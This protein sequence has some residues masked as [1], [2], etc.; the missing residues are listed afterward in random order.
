MLGVIAGIVRRLAGMRKGISN[1]AEGKG[2][3]EL[4]GKEEQ[5]R[6]RA[7]AAG[8]DAMTERGSLGSRA[9][10]VL[11]EALVR[12]DEELMDSNGA[13]LHGDSPEVPMDQEG[14]VSSKGDIISSLDLRFFLPQITRVLNAA[15]LP[16]LSLVQLLAVLQ[17]LATH[18]NAIADEISATLSLV[19]N[20]L[21]VFILTPIPP[22][23]NSPLPV[24]AAIHLLTTL[25]SASRVSASRLLNPVDALL[26]FLTSTPASSPYP[27]S[28]AT[29]LL[30]Q[31]LHLYTTLARYGLYAHITTTAAE[32][33]ARLSSY[34]LAPE[35]D[36]RPLL[37]SYV[38]LLAAW[39]TCASDPH[40]TTPPHDILWSQVSGWG[41]ISVLETVTHKLT[42]ETPDW[43]TWT[44]LWNM[45]A[46]W[47]EGARHNG[48]R[49]GAGERETSIARLRPAFEGKA[50][51]EVVL[52]AVSSLKRLLS[53]TPSGYDASRGLA[54]Y[55]EVAESALVLSAAIRLWLSCL[56][57]DY[58]P[59]P[60]PPFQLPFSLL[61]M[62]AIHVATHPL[63][64]ELHNIPSHFRPFLRPLVSFITNYVWLSR[65]LPGTTPGLWLAQLGT[66]IMRCLPGDEDAARGMLDAVVNLVDEQCL[67][68][69]GWSVP[70]DVWSRG[71]L[72]IL[73]PFLVYG[74]VPRSGDDKQDE[75]TPRVRVAP[76]FP[77]PH[78]LKLATTQCLPST[79][80]FT[81][82]FTR[83][84]PLLPL[85]YLL[86]SGTSPV[87]RHL[88][89]DWDS[90]ETDLVRATLI[91][92]RVVRE[93]MLANGTPTFAMNRTEV[94]FSC[95][96][97]FM[98]EHEQAQG[99]P[100]AS[101]EGREEVFRDDVVGELMEAL[102]LPLILSASPNGLSALSH[103]EEQDNLELAA[104][105]FLG[106]G[107][108]FFQFYTDFVT[109]YDATS[110]GHPLFAAL[111]LP[112]LE[113][114]YAPDY[115]KLLYDDTAHIL[116]TVRTPP[117]RVIGE[118]AGAFLWPAEQTPQIVG[119][120]LGLLIGRRAR[121]PIEGFVRWM[122]V[123]HVA[124]NIWPD[125]R[126]GPSSDAADERGRKL[127][128]TLVTQ[129]EHGVVRDV[130]LYWQRRTGQVVLPPGC[131]DLEPERRRSRHA[132]VKSWAKGDLLERVE[133]LFEVN[134][135][136]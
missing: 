136:Q 47:L 85:D 109:L 54:F 110:F 68:E 119:A 58:E 96:K 121:V 133:G 74:L 55:R 82:L 23:D 107:T 36:S 130:S 28:L 67:A 64:S 69:S 34:I 134:D 114:R 52:G 63:F 62:L 115:R 26:R 122:A 103:T 32:P 128:E 48:V 102:L 76:L 17:R 49:G 39:I 98:L 19:A 116:G 78:S 51:K 92:T 106:P 73:K 127:F 6:K 18:S 77:T 9:V 97:V 80:G 27:L 61:G 95:M 7:I 112:P 45:E 118:A 101:G 30:I 43:G 132:W 86:R 126:E 100:S 46:S 65:R 8:V 111:L 79:R 104:A 25:V 57:L 89:S 42:Q 105:R 21:R 125:L 94:T 1:D 72:R 13:E 131:Y 4:R 20:V 60:G 2:M 38:S 70:S 59:L 50:E 108:P 99:A 24:P 87:W 83:D 56:P 124:A 11:W 71:G 16:H 88:P 37:S 75:E 123:H 41:W 90:S 81:F 14:E 31:T 117:E 53:E 15:D 66:T 129:G 120:M 84:W 93:A 33:L 35:C 44:S 3:E 40:Q 29:N 12:W 5:V 135:Y 10:E 113:Q 91:L 22:A